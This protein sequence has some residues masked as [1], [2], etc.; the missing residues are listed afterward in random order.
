MSEL[1]QKPPRRTGD[2]LLTPDCWNNWGC[3]HRWLLHAT[4]QENLREQAQEKLYEVRQSEDPQGSSF[5]I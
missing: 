4:V 1:L 2:E 3:H 5:Q